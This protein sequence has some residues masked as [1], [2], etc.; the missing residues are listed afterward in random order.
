MNAFSEGAAALSVSEL[1][2]Y[3]R[4]LMAGD[5]LLR[6]VEVT[7]EISGYK[8]H[9]SGHRYFSLKDESARV[10]CVMFRQQAMGLDFQ[11]T[12]GMRVTVRASASVFVRDG[13]FQLYV[14]SMRQ[15]GQGDLYIRFERLKRKLMAEGLFDPARKREIPAFPRVIGVATSQTGAA[16]RD[17]IHVA[18]R[19][20]P[21]IGIVVSPCAVQ[22]A[23]AAREIVRA[24][25]RLNRQ[26]EC[27][28]MLVGRG[29]GSIEDLWAFNEEIVARAIAASR[30]PV[31][32][33]VGHE[34]DFTISDFAADLRA[35]TPS[36]AAELAVPR[37]DEMRAS[38][39][40]LIQRLSGALASAQ[41][42]R[43]LR[44]ERAMA[45]SC[46]SAPARALIEP[47]RL[48][49]RGV[50]ERAGAAMPVLLERGRHRLN[51]MDA[52]LRALN[53]SAVLD[54]GYALVLQE[55][56]VVTGIGGVDTG[57]QIGVRLSDG[58]LTAK[59]LSIAP[60]DEDK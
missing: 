43:R 35:P 34:I 26:G 1:N 42:I 44:L 15:A 9:Y 4:R 54:R 24:I 33:C 31:I 28:V 13:S 58:E 40:G 38:L 45:A 18:R 3:A 47:R 39:S 14:S 22:G 5:P 10:Q 36:A 21:N 16:L 53:P 60:K 51:A 50:W 41:Q 12:D 23:G 59:V 2:E 48:A 19:R 29:G 11:P 7:G 27:D 8:H 30:I 20:D 46:L 6:S 37:L 52:S 17:I 55:G 49:L 56:R 57:A 32:S 25:E